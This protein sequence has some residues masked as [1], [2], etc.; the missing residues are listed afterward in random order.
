MG[1]LA[2][3]L[4]EQGGESI[5]SAE[6]LGG[7]I[8]MIAQGKISGKIAKEILPKMWPRARL[9]KQSCSAKAAAD[10]RHRRARKNRR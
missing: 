9:R 7:L 1:D 8:K 5:V 10:Q 6:N 3:L 4:K 2:A